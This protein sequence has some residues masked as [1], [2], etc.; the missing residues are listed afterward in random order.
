M[1]KP[2][3]WARLPSAEGLLFRREPEQIRS[4]LFAGFGANLLWE[5]PK[6]AGAR[7]EAEDLVP[8]ARRI[9]PEPV[10]E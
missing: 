9:C 2:R 3:E 10:T 4:A 7:S 1:A 6:P 5:E 8:Q